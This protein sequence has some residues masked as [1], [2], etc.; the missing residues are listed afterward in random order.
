MPLV[1]ALGIQDRI[2]HLPAELS[3]GEMQ[4][5]AIARALI[6]QPTLVLADEPTG[7]L[8]STTGDEILGRL[9]EM[10]DRR[11]VT[12]ILMTHD[13]NAISYADRLITLR[14]G[15]I[16]RDVPADLVRPLPDG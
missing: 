5:V 8:D 16:E 13:L 10:C 3:G 15:N 4:R 12:M 11:G 14:D 2:S 6:T 9:R 7:N 1:E